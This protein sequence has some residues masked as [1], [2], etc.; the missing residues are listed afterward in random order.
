MG[1]GVESAPGS[2]SPLGSPPSSP[3]RSKKTIQP[4][5]GGLPPFRCVVK[6][7]FKSFGF[8]FRTFIIFI[9]IL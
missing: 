9:W 6:Q 8:F 3:G 4:P 1:G 5:P 7:I 2:S